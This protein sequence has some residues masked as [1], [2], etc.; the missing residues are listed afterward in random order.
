MPKICQATKNLTSQ[1]RKSGLIRTLV[2]LLTFVLILGFLYHFINKK[3]KAEIEKQTESFLKITLDS[4]LLS[5][6]NWLKDRKTSAQTISHFP[7]LAINLDKILNKEF[8]DELSHCLKNAYQ[9]NGFSNVIICN[10]N[11]DI[12]HTDQPYHQ[13]KLDSD[14]QKKLMPAW[15]N[16]FAFCEPLDEENPHLYFAVPVKNDTS[17]MLMIFTVNPCGEFSRIL[18]SAQYGESAETYAI[19]NASYMISKSRFTDELIKLKLIDSETSTLALQLK[20]PGVNL[21]EGQ[22]TN[23]AR[24]DLPRTLMAQKVTSKSENVVYPNIEINTQGYN[25]YRGVKV[26]GAWTWLDDYNFGLATEVDHVEAYKPLNFLQ[27]TFNCLI[28]LLILTALII[29]L[30]NIIVNKLI[31]KAYRSGRAIKQL[32]QYQ[33]QKLIGEGGMGEVHIAK[34]A[35]L[36]RPTAVKLIKNHN[37]ESFGRFEREVQLTCRLSHPNTIAI[38]DYGRTDENVFYYAME[39]LDGID[40]RV[41]IDETGP[42]QISRIIFLMRQVCGSL[43]E[44]HDIGL[45]HRDIKPANIF[46][47]RKGGLFDFAKVL[48]FGLVKETGKQSSQFEVTMDAQVTGTPYYISPEAIQTPDKL[49]HATDIYSLG[50]VMYFLAT[51]RHAFE[52]DTI[53]EIFMKHN[54][55]K[56]APMSER[57]RFNIPQDFEEVVQKCLEKDPAK[58]YASMDELSE[59]LNAL[60]DNVWSHEKAKEWWNRNSVNQDYE[61][62]CNLQ[63]EDIAQDLQNTILIQY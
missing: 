6:K 41:M 51:D 36:H 55:E 54:K 12:V 39:Y 19:N 22:T 18:A 57:V 20:D 13:G 47:C 11:F 32:G 50:C 8:S 46:C 14:L 56:P 42:L 23:Q 49:T 5:L 24:E 1:K 27:M 58:R 4:N 26:I 34:H 28:F 52:G 62:N 15:K 59:A 10:E 45:I 63:T 35:M 2:I 17:Q 9:I 16:G 44:A 43:Q 60:Q 40:L 38:Y 3:L 53:M 37:E 30:Y 29:V 33:L 7:D 21:I 25:D 61:K 48:D 31:L